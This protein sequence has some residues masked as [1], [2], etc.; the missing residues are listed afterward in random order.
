MA[1][2]ASA[3][4][5]SRSCFL[6]RN[7]QRRFFKQQWLFFDFLLTGHHYNNYRG[8]NEKAQE[9]PAISHSSPFS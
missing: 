8:Q 6:I 7:H 9:I 2:V 4:V 3:V 5:R 1:N